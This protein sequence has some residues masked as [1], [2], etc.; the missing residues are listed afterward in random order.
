MH[1]KSLPSAGE[2]LGLLDVVYDLERPNGDWLTGVIRAF[3]N[4]FGRDAG[5]GGLLYDASNDARIDVDLLTTFGTPSRFHDTGRAIHEDPRFVPEIIASYRTCLCAA[6]GELMEDPSG[7]EALRGDYYDPNGVRGQIMINGIDSS[8]K[9]CVIYMFS[10]K[11]VALSGGERQIMRMLATHLAT[12]YRLQRRIEARGGGAD[13]VLTP[14]GRVEHAEA[15]ARAPEARESLR[16]AVREREQA[17]RLGQGAERIVATAKG[18]VA[19]RW[20]LVDGREVG[21]RRYVL[22]RENAPGLVG[23][24]RLTDRERQVV[25]LAALGR[26]NKLIA[27]ELGLA[28]STVRVLM[29]RACGKLGARTR[30][31]LV[32]R[33][34]RWA[35]PEVPTE[36]GRAP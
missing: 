23:P 25:A 27:Y 32:N 24:R 6:L 21:G 33:R 19:A 20:T 13:A 4:T 14:L 10:T 3:S 22:A 2:L 34:R 31:E 30:N 16:L 29:A 12:A 18:L 7:A 36:R 9:G 26:T 8:G 35:R 5:A 28:H 1:S 17:R 15:D 11:P